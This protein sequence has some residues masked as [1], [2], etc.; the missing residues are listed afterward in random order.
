MSRR[1]RLS[2]GRR[3]R[4]PALDEMLE[5]CQ[6]HEVAGVVVVQFDRLA[7]SLVHMVKLAQGF[8]EKGIELVSLRDSIDTNT[9]MG[10]AMFGIL[11]GRAVRPP[12]GFPP[13]PRRG[14]G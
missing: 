5:V 2:S 9:A 7:R 14:S 13:S 4:R 1:G 12:V 8:E 11:A 3:D 10:K 6:K